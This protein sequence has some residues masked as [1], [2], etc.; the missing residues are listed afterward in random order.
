MR[1]D[2]ALLLEHVKDAEGFRSF[3]YRCSADKLTIGYGRNLE[4]NGITEGEAGFLLVADIGSAIEDAERLDYFAALDPV[5]QMVVVDMIFNLGAARFSRFKKL[6]AALAL[7][8]YTLAAHEMMD[9][10]WYTQ[11]GR[12]AKKL[13]EAM[14]TGIW[15]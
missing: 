9:S 11:V 10:K 4:D 15:K 7:P 1:F 2:A 6:N 12:R 5:R 14:I 13:R 8:D 3:P